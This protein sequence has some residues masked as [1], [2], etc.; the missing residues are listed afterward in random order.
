ME[1]RD[2]NE[3]PEDY[4]LLNFGNFHQIL[5]LY[6]VNPGRESVLEAI[7]YLSQREDI[8]SAEPRYINIHLPVPVDPPGDGSGEQDSSATP[9]LPPTGDTAGILGLTLVL[10]LASLGVFMVTKNNL[11]R[12]R[13]SQR[14]T[15]TCNLTHCIPSA[16]SGIE[17]RLV[18][19]SGV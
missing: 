10:S 5:K 17:N 19:L 16:M 14:V 18:R 2:P 11:S 1:G 15:G 8:L 6:L 9:S 4:P 3:Y 12:G 7:E 13:V